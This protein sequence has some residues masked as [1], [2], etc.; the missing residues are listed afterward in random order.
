MTIEMLIVLGVILA[1][2]ILFISEWISPDLVALTAMAALL[3]SGILTPV[4]AAS[5]FGNSATL[6]VGAM[7]VLSAGLFK[8]GA[9]NFAGLI[10]ARMF[11]FNFWVGIAIMMLFAGGLSAFINNTAVVAIFMPVLLATARDAKISASKVLLPLSYASMFGGC[12]TLIGTST[13]IL[14]SSIAEASGQHAFAMFEMSPLG[15]IFFGVGILYMLIAGVRLIPARRSTAEL[16]EEY[17]MGDYLTDIVLLPDAKTIGKTLRDS[18]LTRDVGIVV[19]DVFRNQEKL[20][21]SEDTVLKAGDVLRIIGHVGMINRLKQRQ[22][23]CFGSEKNCRTKDFPWPQ[24]L[25]VEAVI[26][27]NSG[28]E[29]N[30]LKGMRFRNAFDANVLAI[31]HRGEVM[32]EN[33]PEISLKTGDVLLIEIEPHHLDQLKDQKDFLIVS[34]VP[35]PR[36]RTRKALSALAIVAGVVLLAALE[37]FPIMAAAVAGAVL[38]VASGCISTEEAYQAMDWRVLMLLAGIL[39]LGVALQK[40]GAAQAA[41]HFVLS[42]VGQWGPLAVLATFYL[43]TTLMTEIMSN[44]AT[45]VL[46]APIAIAAAESMGIHSRPLLMA[47]SFAA[48]ASFMTPI[49]YQTNLM[50]Y[51]TG[52]YKF[53]DFV[54]VGTPLDIL[55]FMLAP[56]LIPYFWPFQ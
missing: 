23:I 48:S 35:L 29:G 49:G 51:G 40:T 55:F 39:P 14:V 19:L 12:C 45:A 37:V 5:G 34:E 47:V 4:E 6:T 26:A 30:T 2:L 27:P 9:V 56:V 16:R 15:L 52:G 7:I 54:K 38:M 17:G 31:R 28:L 3:V 24:P 18:P 53:R 11:R 13:N 32:H 44:N 1:T 33:L 36:F 25:L 43:L 21:L 42:T 46:L 41:A 10:F 8:T 20:D 50:V 22:G